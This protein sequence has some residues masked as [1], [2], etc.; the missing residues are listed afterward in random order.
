MA[1]DL[2]VWTI[3]AVESMIRVDG[4]GLGRNRTGSGQTVVTW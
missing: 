1:G 2:I 3:M 4:M